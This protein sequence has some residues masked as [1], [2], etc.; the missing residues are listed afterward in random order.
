LSKAELRQRVLD[1]GAA[2]LADAGVTVSLYHLNMEELIRRVGVP[3]S[4]AFAA[5]GGKEELI[6]EL[7]VQLLRPR[8][9]ASIGFSPSTARVAQQAIARHA[10]RL[11]RA[12][13]TPDPDGAYAVLRETV[14][15]T[16][17]QNVDDTASSPEWQTFMALSASV[18]SLPPGRREK[19]TEALRVAETQFV[20]AMTA[21]YRD[22]FPMLGRRL[23]AGVEWRHLVTAGATIVEGIVSRRRMGAPVADDVILA[24]GID[25]EPVEWTL[26]ALAY[27]AVIDGFTEPVG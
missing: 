3:R 6:I 14:R 12:D 11:T 5:F 17:P 8:P 9:G 22:A 20:E 27:L 18:P 23:R 13:G 16:L 1:E 2:L 25:G 7:M 4:S 26:A 15:M 21:F 19:V 10:S 24:P